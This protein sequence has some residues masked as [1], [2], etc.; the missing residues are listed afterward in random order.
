MSTDSVTGQLAAFAQG[1]TWKSIPDAIRHEAK[2][3]LLNYF[4]CALAGSQDDAVCAALRALGPL[5]GP[6]KASVIGHSARLDTLTASFLNGM[7]GNILDFDDTHIPTVM[8]PTA[9]IVAPLFAYAE[10]EATSGRDLLLSFVLGFEI[11]CRIG[12]TVALGGHYRR[13][14]HITATCGVFGGAI[15]VAK[16]MNLSAKQYSALFAV[17]AGQA[18]G[19]VENLG[20]TAKGISVGNAARNGYLAALLVREGFEGPAHPIEGQHGFVRVTSEMSD[21]GAL[22]AD[23]GGSWELTKNTYKPYPTGVVLNPVIDACLELRERQGLSAVDVASV[24]VRAHPLLFER[25][26]RP[27]VASGRE[28]VVSLQHTVSVTMLFGAAGL[29]QFTDI[30]VQDPA[31]LA[32]RTKVSGTADEAVPVGVATVSIR[33]NDGRSFEKTVTEA[34]GRLERPLTDRQIEEKLRSLA[35]FSAPWCD[36]ARLIDA[37]WNLDSLPAAASV[38]VLA[39]PPD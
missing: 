21:F 35:A 32:L 39:T 29:A 11:A 9:P 3:S 6:P 18:A 16:Q 10:Q 37:V 24:H 7:G 31:V 20:T 2:R 12:N 13:G 28:S 23:L 15:G 33:T 19:L 1:T 5:S 30:M 36:T 26:D 34:L 4:G 38:M 14:W 17:A 27:N 22:V 8:H 25:T